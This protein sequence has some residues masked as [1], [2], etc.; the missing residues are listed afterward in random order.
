MPADPERGHGGAYRLVDGQ[1]VLEQRT[2][3]AAAQP[4]EP[5]TTADPTVTPTA[6]GA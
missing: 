6:E 2:Q 4:S 5:T 3:A 1:R